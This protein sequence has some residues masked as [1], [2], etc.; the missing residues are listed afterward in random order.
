MIVGGLPD[1]VIV[2][3]LPGHGPHLCGEV[4]DGEAIG[5]DRQREGGI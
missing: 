5:C 2:F 3:G 4:G 1:G